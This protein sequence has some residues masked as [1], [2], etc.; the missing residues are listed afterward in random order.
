MAGSRWV[1][2]S[3]WSMMLLVLA[4]ASASA[5]FVK[6]RKLAEPAGADLALDLPILVVLCITLNALFL[7]TIRKHN[8]Y[9]LM[10]QVSVACGL[11]L[12]DIYLLESKSRLV[13]YIAPINFA[14]LLLI[15]FVLRRLGKRKGPR[16]ARQNLVRLFY[17]SYAAAVINL[18]F[19]V[20]ESMVQSVAFGVYQ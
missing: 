8:I 6:V 4:S 9:Q 5:L 13:H 2:F 3:I 20:V 17:R 15:P 14:A 16:T 11:L 12:G 19:L 1:R 18:L 10:I 7:T